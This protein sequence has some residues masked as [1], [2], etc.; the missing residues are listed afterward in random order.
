MRRLRRHLKKCRHRRRLR[1]NHQRALSKNRQQVNP[2]RIDTNPILPI[3]L[4][5]RL[6]INVWTLKRIVQI[7]VE[8]IIRIMILH[9][10]THQHRGF[11]HLSQHIIWTR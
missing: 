6:D 8:K 10:A 2:K 11:I 4:A 9:F 3:N 5:L 7:I 1:R